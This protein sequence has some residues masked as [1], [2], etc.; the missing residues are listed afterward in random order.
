MRLTNNFFAIPKLLVQDISLLK[1]VLRIRYAAIE[2]GSI[3]KQELVPEHPLALSVH[4]NRQLP[5]LNLNKEQALQ[6]LRKQD[7]INADLTGKKGWHLMQYEKSNLGWAKLLPNRIN[8]YYPKEW[9]I[10]KS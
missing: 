2:M 4:I 6:Y 7:I 3:N 5:I 1:N 9:R 8:N 10:L